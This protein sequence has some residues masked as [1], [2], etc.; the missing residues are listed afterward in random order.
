MH[1]F[2]KAIFDIKLRL[3]EFIL[4]SI[5]L[6]CGVCRYSRSAKAVD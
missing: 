2:S 6:I 1:Q 3:V 5:C 4:N